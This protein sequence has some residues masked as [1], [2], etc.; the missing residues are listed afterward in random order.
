MKTLKNLLLFTWLCTSSTLLGQDFL[1]TTN[2]DTLNGDIKQLAKGVVTIETDYSD[3]D[4][5]VEWDKVTAVNAPETYMIQL[6][7]GTRYIDSLRMHNK[8]TIK[9]R[10]GNEFVLTSIIEVVSFKKVDQDFWSRLSATIDFGFS[11]AKNNNL[12]QLSTRT[13]IGYL[14][15]NW[16]L[17]FSFNS[18]QSSQDEIADVL[19]RE[20]KL[21]YTYFFGGNFFAQGSFNFLSNTEQFL[22]LRRTSQLAIGSYLVQTNV[23]YWNY[24]IGV[25]SNVETY[26]TEENQDRQSVE[27]SI[28]SEYN[29]FDGKDLKLTIGIVTYTS[30]T[31]RGR[32]RTDADID[33]KYD[34]PLDFYIGIGGSLN[35]DN[36]PVEIEGQAT[37]Q[38]DYVTQIN[39]GWDL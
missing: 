8:D 31:E 22:D 38:T 19:R 30:L 29:L 32:F 33:L 11:Y 10:Y 2:G 5:K 7:D 23:D 16:Q 15:D 36:Q 20:T 13:T 39:F 14:T 18:V 28:G 25:A 17:D 37:Q 35:Y 9:L 26:S 12:T 3:S 24:G 34:L 27:L 1:V 21:G 6:S 4:F